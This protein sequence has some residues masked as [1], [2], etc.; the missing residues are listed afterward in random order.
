MDAVDNRSAIRGCRASV[1]PS[2]HEAVIRRGEADTSAE[3]IV[4]TLS[5]TDEAQD[6]VN[7]AVE[8]CE[9][10]H[11]RMIWTTR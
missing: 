7:I 4:G 2:R 9:R 10:S 3:V 5:R 1:Q 6:K 8:S 11:T